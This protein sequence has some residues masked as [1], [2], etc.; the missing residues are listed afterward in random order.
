[1][2][3]S[4]SPAGAQGK[5]ADGDGKVLEMTHQPMRIYER[6]SGLGQTEPLTEDERLYDETCRAIDFGQRAI[7]S[8]SLSLFTAG[9][10]ICFNAF[11]TKVFIF[12]NQADLDVQ[13]KY[14]GDLLHSLEEREKAQKA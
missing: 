13:L 10:F 4:L 14:L 12:P 2:R 7:M 5:H 9:E 8:K 6:Y 3:L 1:M 11:V